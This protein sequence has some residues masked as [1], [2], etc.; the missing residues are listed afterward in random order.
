MER[1]GAHLQGTT[2]AMAAEPR[3]AAYPG[4]TGSTCRD[5]S[6]HIYLSS[7]STDSKV[8]CPADIIMREGLDCLTPN[9]D[10]LTAI[11]MLLLCVL[12]H[13]TST[14]ETILERNP[15]RFQPL[16]E[17]KEPEYGQRHPTPRTFFPLQMCLL[18]WE[19]LEFLR[20]VLVISSLCILCPFTSSTC[21]SMRA[22][23]VSN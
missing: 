5:L 15:E 12:K 10:C 11:S 8:P 14:G 23:P 4:E 17:D 22:V 13:V 18:I 21:G 1:P 16:P 2:A 9:L 3:E 6:S 7:P 19:R 20:C